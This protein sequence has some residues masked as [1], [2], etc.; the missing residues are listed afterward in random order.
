MLSPSDVKKPAK[1]KST[2]SAKDI[3]ACLIWL[4]T[5][6]PNSKTELTYE[7]SFQL[8]T[9]VIL[10]AQCTDARVNQ[11]TPALFAAYPDA[12]AMA[13]APLSTIEKLIQSCGFYR[14]KA[15]ALKGMSERV[16]KDYN[17]EIPGDLDALTSLPGVGRKTASVIL[18][19]AFDIPAIAVDTHVKRVS[20]R[21]GWSFH[22]HP[23]K[24]EF[25]LRE[26]IPEKD[27]SEINGLLILHGRRICKARKPLCEECGIK[28]YCAFYQTTSKLK[29]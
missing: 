25:E 14:M 13:K 21:L 11:T 22:P 5:A 10:S 6:Y 20:N 17:G 3:Q 19:Q 9:A 16:L 1:Q 27:W 26:L 2:P 28:K 24:I 7:T 23:E 18:N 12:K 8:L 29:T 15:K 4:R